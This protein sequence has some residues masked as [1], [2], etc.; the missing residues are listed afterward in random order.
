MLSLEDFESLNDDDI[1][2]APGLFLA[3]DKD[4]PIKLRVRPHGRVGDSLM[5]VVTYFGVTLGRWTCTKT[6]AELTWQF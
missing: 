6:G 4:E 1:V 3:L 2:E 5:F